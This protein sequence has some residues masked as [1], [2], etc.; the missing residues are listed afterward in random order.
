MMVGTGLAAKNGVLIRDPDALELA[1]WMNAIALDKTGTLTAGKPKL[2]KIEGSDPDRA[3]KIAASI[4][5]GSEHPLAFA[6]LSEAKRRGFNLDEVPSS[7]HQAIPG[8][9]IMARVLGVPYGLGN[10]RLL[11]DH[12]AVIPSESSEL[13]TCSYLLNLESREIEGVFD[14]EDEL[15][16]TA[17]SLIR[18]FEKMKVKPILLSGDSTAVVASVA[19]ILG[20]SDFKGSLT[21]EEK[22]LEIRA[23]QKAGLCIGMIGD[24]VNDAPALAAADIGI[25]LSSGTDVAMQTAGI[26]IMGNDPARALVAIL[27][28]RKTYSRIRYNLL[29]AFG[30]NVV[31]IPLAASGALSP[32]LAG[33]AMAFSSVSVVASSLLLAR[34]KI[35]NS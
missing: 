10:A 35:P 22:A 27:I 3:L 31:C 26:T 23:Y 14:F 30:Y 17:I 12:G 19:R 15:K 34:T 29:W 8:R 20:I 4:Q 28:S 13:Y 32:T 16:P 21:P 5:K 24:G 2:V 11:L 25:A 18:S 33:L 6:V 1:H 7:G 9:G